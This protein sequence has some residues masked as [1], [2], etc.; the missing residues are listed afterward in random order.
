[1]DPHNGGGQQQRG[2]GPAGKRAGM[3]IRKDCP[4][5]PAAAGAGVASSSDLDKDFDKNAKLASLPPSK[6]G[7][8][9]GI[10][11]VGVSAGLHHTLLLSKCGVVYAFGSNSY[12]QLGTGDLI[13]RGT[14]T[15]LSL[16]VRATQVAAGAYHSVVM[17]ASGEVFT[18]GASAKNQLGRTQ[19]DPVA[20]N[21][22]AAR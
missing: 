16:P 19:P 2:G 10:K 18:F 9:K 12:G 8:P 11:I 1:M 3:A 15:P 14:P 13:P 20:S 6:V 7:L 4:D 17:T 21:D 5:S 22:V